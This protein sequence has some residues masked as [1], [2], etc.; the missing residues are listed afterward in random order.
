MESWGR[1]HWEANGEVSVVEPAR[2]NSNE[3]H[4]GIKDSTH[5]ET[6]SV[7]DISLTYVGHFPCSNNL[8]QWNSFKSLFPIPSYPIDIYLKFLSQNLVWDY[9][10]VS[11]MMYSASRVTLCKVHSQIKLSISNERFLYDVEYREP[12]SKQKM[13]RRE[14]GASYARSWNLWEVADFLKCT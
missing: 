14:K 8:L 7:R 2:E 10:T 5:W 6:R 11:N 9:P 1:P 4:A 3:G 12:A 13:R